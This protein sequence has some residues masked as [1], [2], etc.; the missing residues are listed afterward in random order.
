MLQGECDVRLR[1]RHLTIRPG[2]TLH[3]PQGTKHEVA[4]LGWEPAVYVCSFSASARGTL[5]E[6]PSTPGVR[7]LS[8][9]HSQPW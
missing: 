6:D 1:D 3:I 2:Q 7:P 9:K 8:G 4:N 5:F